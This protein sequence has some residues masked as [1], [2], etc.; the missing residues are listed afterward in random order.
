M[1]TRDAPNGCHKS[2]EGGFAAVS[3]EDKDESVLGA[4]FDLRRVSRTYQR[5]TFSRAHGVLRRNVR[6][7]FTL[8]L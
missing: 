7:D 4:D 1:M 5:S 2:V 6:L 3:P 8:G